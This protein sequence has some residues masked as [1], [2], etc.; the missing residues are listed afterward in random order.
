MQW[1]NY[2]G[3]GSNTNYTIMHRPQTGGPWTMVNDGSDNQE[4]IYF[5]TGGTYE[6]IIQTDHSDGRQSHS[7]MISVD[8]T[9]SAP[10]SINYLASASVNGLEIDLHH[11]V[12]PS[13]N[14][15]AI[16][17]ERKQNDG[18]FKEIDR[19]PI[20]GPDTYFTD[21]TASVNKVNVYRAVLV[22]ICGSQ[23]TFLK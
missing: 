11:F 18:S 1:T 3:W 5:A 10:P 21:I 4:S 22:D 6:F 2:E 8:V 7:N 23:N 16:A 13:A 19:V 15:M 20:V 17:F 14:V 12:D 9:A